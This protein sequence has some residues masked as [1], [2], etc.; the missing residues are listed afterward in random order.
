[1][2]AGV[3]TGLLLLWAGAVR[4]GCGGKKET[5]YITIGDKYING[6]PGQGRFGGRIAQQPALFGGP[7]QPSR[8]KGKQLITQPSK[9]G[10]N[11]GTFGKWPYKSDP[12][13]E[14][15]GFLASQPADK[16]KL[17]FGSHDAYKSAEFTS[18]IATK[19][20]REALKN[21]LAAMKKPVDELDRKRMELEA[22]L[23]ATRA[24]R[25]AIQRGRNKK[26]HDSHYDHAA[27]EDFTMTLPGPE[28]LYDMGR[29]H[30]T[31]YDPQNGEDKFYNRNKAVGRP[32]VGRSK[33]YNQY[34]RPQSCQYGDGA[35]VDFKPSFTTVN[36]T[37][38]VSQISFFCAFL[39][40]S[41]FAW[42]LIDAALQSCDRE[43]YN[44]SHL[45]TN[46]ME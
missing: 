37:K 11:D 43:F 15:A 45:R 1:M 5:A 42:N 35:P 8:T 28:G 19:R 40:G 9:K 2:D 38:P 21:Q 32:G 30:V 29:K 10:P 39:R 36:L 6:N 17:G 20:Y 22:K 41:Y 44:P 26:W 13:K 46:Q 25:L 24:K 34:N 31:K 33:R 4:V 18:T 23:E 7:N 27:R 3:L 16:R 12:Y 14:G